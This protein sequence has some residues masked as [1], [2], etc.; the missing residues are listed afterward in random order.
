MVSLTS[1]RHRYKFLTFV[2]TCLALRFVGG[3]G[4]SPFYKVLGILALDNHRGGRL[5]E[6]F[7][8]LAGW[9]P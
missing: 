6:V 3:A 7:C 8:F 9:R 1:V 5:L 4:P 2:V